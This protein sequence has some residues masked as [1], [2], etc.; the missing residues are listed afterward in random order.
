MTFWWIKMRKNENTNRRHQGQGQCPPETLPV[1]VFPQI[2][3][4]PIWHRFS[5]VSYLLV[6][7]EGNR[8][9]GGFPPPPPSEPISAAEKSKPDKMGSL[10]HGLGD[11]DPI[12]FHF[13]CEEL[14]FMAS[15]E[16]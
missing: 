14:N 9:G 16:G 6:L 12:K 13:L 2:V 5:F 4:D 10:F 3:Q 11:P 8:F 1:G 7:S 15:N